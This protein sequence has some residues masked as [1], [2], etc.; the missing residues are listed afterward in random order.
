[1][2]FAGQ[3]PRRVRHAPLEPRRTLAGH[4]KF[5]DREDSGHRGRAVEPNAASPPRCCRMNFIPAPLGGDPARFADQSA[6]LEGGY[7][8]AVPSGAG[9][10]TVHALF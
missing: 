8:V 2:K 9:A 3:H 1:M 7:P 10:K 6:I 5:S 4:P